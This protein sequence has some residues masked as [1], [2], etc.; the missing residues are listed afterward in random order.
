MATVTL[1]NL[2][3]RKELVMMET[4][5]VNFH[6]SYYIPAIKISRFI[7]HTYAFYLLI[8]VVTNAVNY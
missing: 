7:F 2:Y 3:T 8:P 1:A 5:I 6:T 4:Y